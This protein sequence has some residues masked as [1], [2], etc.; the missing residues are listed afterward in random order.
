MFP[1]V[2]GAALRNCIRIVRPRPFTPGVI[3]MPYVPA[4][5]IAPRVVRRAVQKKIALGCLGGA[6]VVPP[7][8]ILPGAPAT[9]L[10]PP[11]LGPPPP[12]PWGN[13]PLLPSL[14]LVPSSVGGVPVLPY[15]GEVAEAAAVF[16]PS[17]LMLLAPLVMMIFCLYVGFK[18]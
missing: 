7:L 13:G 5:T 15:V 3:R 17:S 10:P 16:E 11:P 14:E 6:L 18:K 12:F 9:P 2:I 8:A 1:N 4:A